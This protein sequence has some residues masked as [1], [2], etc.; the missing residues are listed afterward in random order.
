MKNK[1]TILYGSNSVF[2][3]VK[4]N[5]RTVRKV[6]LEE[7]FND[8]RI[9]NIINENNI[10]VED[11]KRLISHGGN[12]KTAR[13]VA[14]L[15]D[16]FKYASFEGLLDMGAATTLI[17]LDRVYDPQNLGAVIRS[18]ACFGGFAVIIPQHKACGVTET[19]LRV[20]CGGE[21]HVPVAVVPNIPQAIR[22]AKDAGFFVA[23]GMLT[24]DALDIASASLSFPLG[25]V[26][27]SEGK[28]IRYGVEKNLDLKVKIP[29]AGGRISFNVAA[30]CAIFC[31]D[32]FMRKRRGV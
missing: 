23:G 30:A 27:G 19:V 22:Q 1:F 6:F 18:A 28:G 11:L 3:R 25:L 4:I 16:N 29:M 31:Y 14:A 20:A 17:F 8:F 13:G 10:R 15:V 5:P 32:I 7:D 24:R 21:N 9:K 26:L 2:E 12:L